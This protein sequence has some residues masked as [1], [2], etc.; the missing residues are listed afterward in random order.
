MIED[1]N[2]A[3][4]KVGLHEGIA[5]PYLPWSLALSHVGLLECFN[6]A[7]DQLLVGMAKKYNLERPDP[8]PADTKRQ[9]SGENTPLERIW[10]SDGLGLHN[11]K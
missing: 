7:N 3:A 11:S 5:E 8:R 9:V 1:E 6:L 10:D 4:G 2:E